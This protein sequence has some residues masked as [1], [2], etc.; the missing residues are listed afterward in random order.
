MKKA[1]C[2]FIFG[3]LN[4]LVF[5]QCDLTQFRWD[6]E[7]P[8]HIKPTRGASSLVYCGNSWGYVTKAQYDLIA[9]YQ[10]A[11]VEMAVMVNGEYVDSPC[12][13]SGR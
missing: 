4:S 13:P 9:R 2:I 1:L 5:A 11:N 3:L 12:I 10:R 6:C 8:F 7:M